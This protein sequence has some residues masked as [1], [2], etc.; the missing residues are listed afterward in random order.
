MVKHSRLRTQRS[1]RRRPAI[2]FAI[3]LIC[4]IIVSWYHFDIQNLIR[5][6]QD[7]FHTAQKALDA[8]NETRGTV[9][10]RNF[11]EI[12]VSLEK[13]SV[14]ARMS[15]LHSLQETVS[16]LSSVLRIDESKIMERLQGDS[17]K[18]WLVQNI[19]RQQEEAVRK[20]SL[21]GIFLTEEKARFYPQERTAAHLVGFVEADIGLAGIEYYYDTLLSRQI[22]GQEAIVQR[23]PGFPH[24]VLT[25]DLK[26]QAIL[27]KLVEELVAGQAG[28]RAGAFLME[29]G[30]GAMVASVQYPSFNPNTFQKYSDDIL[31]NLFLEPL[32]LPVEYRRFLRDSAD[33]QT[34]SEV[35]GV[36]LPWSVGVTSDSLGSQ[37]RLWD[38]VGMNE[39]PAP[40]FVEEN[41]LQS[42]KLEMQQI[43][44]DSDEFFDTVPDRMSPLQLLT[45]VAGLLNGGEKVKAHAASKLVDPGTKK[46]FPLGLENKKA[47]S[48][49]TVS[50]ETSR[51]IMRLL[52]SQAKQGVLDSVYFSAGNLVALGVKS[53]WT[54]RQNNLLLTV[55]PADRPE[56]VLLVVLETPS[57]KPD[58]KTKKNLDLTTA[59]DAVV[60]RIA[61]LQQVGLTVN[62]V[63][64]AG[65][66]KKINYTDGK[67]REEKNKSIRLSSLTEEDKVIPMPDLKGLSLRKGLRQLQGAN[68]K[69]RIVGTGKILAQSPKPGEMLTKNTE[70]IL[71]LQKDED[72]QLKN[73]EKKLPKKK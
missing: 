72:I 27:E 29:A 4:I 24:L 25:L 49:K 69:L 12:A 56:L 57:T 53:P 13:V 43:S 3:L 11:K 16:K 38:R 23:L 71:T 1:T 70:C 22:S 66:E 62:D 41:T 9:Y 42:A 21:P 34:Q 32:L 50:P 8:G 44:S 14:C 51:E 5:Q 35:T 7:F 17:L 28:V 19:S 31:A 6:C 18:N 54:I 55:I 46:E 65:E 2:L 47:P 63:I 45:A 37:L 73:L 52:S 61:V 67:P 58:T 60:E 33:L 15:E 40:E 20:L 10:D 48:S 26:I 39:P 36:R 64:S 68:V 59:V 30:T